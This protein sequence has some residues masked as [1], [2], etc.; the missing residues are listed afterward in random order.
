VRLYYNKRRAGHKKIKVDK[1]QKYVI[2]VVYKE[3]SL[4]VR[5]ITKYNN[6]NLC[7][8]DTFVF[9]FFKKSPKKQGKGDNMSQIVKTSKKKTTAKANILASNGKANGST[10]TITQVGVDN[11]LFNN[12]SRLILDAPITI[13]GTPVQQIEMVSVDLK[14]FKG[15]RWLRKPTA[16]NFVK[17]V[18]Q[19]DWNL[20]GVVTVAEF[21]DGSRQVIDGGHRIHMA[22]TSVP[23]ITEVPAIIVQVTDVAMAARI[24]ARFNAT[25]R[26]SLNPEEIF[27]NRVLGEERDAL[28]L[29]QALL[30]CGVHV[31]N[32][33]L[34]MG[35][36]S[37]KTVKIRAFEKF[38][39]N[40]P[41]EYETALGIIDFVFV[42]EKSVNSMLTEG[43]VK[44][45]QIIDTE[46]SFSRHHDSLVDFMAHAE[47]GGR[48]QKMFNYA[49]IRKHNH[50][51]ISVAW[52]LYQEWYDWI[53]KNDSGN[54]PILKRTIK[55]LYD[56]AGATY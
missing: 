51:A 18:G 14:G 24:F 49:D 28:I 35:D 41:R 17:S 25:G 33:L 21:P 30:D 7:N 27:I 2:I 44:L 15:Q 3:L 43:L 54:A 46:T 48:K 37:G 55:D 20:F 42:N 45:I 6:Q 23:Q 38:Y 53:Q 10:D 11:L 4:V 26:T 32:K 16:D 29:E 19:F 50:T 12:R 8:A 34:K 39:T 9:A 56:K 52:G 47:K 22:K 40:T 1:P 31:T 5:K 36:E 13:V